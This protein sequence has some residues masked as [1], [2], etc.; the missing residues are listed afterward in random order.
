MTQHLIL[1]SHR[2]PALQARSTQL[3]TLSGMMLPSQW[4][5]TSVPPLLLKSTQLPTL[6]GV[7]RL[8]RLLW[9]RSM[10]TLLL[11]HRQLRQAKTANYHRE[12]SD[13]T[14]PLLLLPM[15][16]QPPT[17]SGMNHH[18]VFTMG[19]AAIQLAPSLVGRSY[20]LLIQTE[21]PS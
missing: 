20:D 3:L 6:D 17:L 11:Q 4:R 14:L 18:R 2:A 21:G 7:L 5:D 10:V 1:L 16:T 8:Q 9:L 19:Q 12:T 15:S 13:V